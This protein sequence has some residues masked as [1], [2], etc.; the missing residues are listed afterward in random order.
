MF[1]PMPSV[2]GVKRH[3]EKS[4]CL[5]WLTMASSVSSS[6]PFLCSSSSDPGPRVALITGCSEGGIGHALAKELAGRG[7]SVIATSR[8][9]SSVGDDLRSQSNVEVVDLDVTSS[10]SVSS[11]V[12]SILQKY[13][14]ID[15]LI[16]NAGVPCNAPIAEVPHSLVE[17]TFQTN[18]FG[19]ISLIRAVAPY[20]VEAR[21]G[22]IVNI[23]SIGGF[24]AG[25]WSG[26]YAASKSALHALTD[27][28]RL[29]LRPFGVQVIL[30]A[31]GGVVSN[32]PKAAVSVI[33]NIRYAIYKSYEQDIRTRAK[34]SQSSR[35]IP[36]PIFA[37]KVID[38][39]LQK[40]PPRCFTYGY[41]SWTYSFLYFMPL[42]L[43]DR[44]FSGKAGLDKPLGIVP[45]MSG[46][47]TKIT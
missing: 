18:V 1:R 41:L 27:S 17:G 43:R 8:S 12:S 7:Y 16:N 20:M 30:V 47:S 3:I 4:L 33:Q 13:G 29:E 21:Q 31:P 38:V 40:N 9:A 24:I 44:Y 22:K 34:Y 14:R 11:T 10:I 46:V 32:F 36:T 37:R 5:V 2:E 42:W 26:I 6:L 35:S 45:H 23:G 19:P 15:I 28:L 39:V 25:P